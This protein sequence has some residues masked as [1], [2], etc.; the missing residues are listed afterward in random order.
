MNEDFLHFTWKSKRFNQFNLATTDGDLVEII[1]AGLHNHHAGPDF[2][3][4]RVRIGGTLWI[5]NVEIHIKASDWNN[6]KHQFDEAYDNVILHVV[7]EADREIQN[8]KGQTLPAMTLQERM[9]DD[10]FVAYQG[11]LKSTQWVACA[12]QLK[13]VD[14]FIK[15]AWLHRML[16]SRLEQKSERVAL[17]LDQNKNDWEGA[18]YRQ[19]AR[20]FGFKVNAEPFEMLVFHLPLKV[21]AKQLHSSMQIEAMVFGQAGFLE[22][23]FSDA[24]P[25][26]LQK[27][28]QYLKKKHKLNAMAKSIWK[29][30][31]LRPNNFPTIRLA[32]FAAM[33]AH[34]Q[35]LFSRS[36]EAEN[37][38][39]LFT[40]F[41]VQPHS[42]WDDHF[43][44]DKRA[45]TSRPKLLGRAAFENLVINT[46]VPFLFHYGKL[47]DKQHLCDRA[48]QLLE[49]LKPE[50][51]SVV[52]KWKSI[53]M[54][55]LNAFHSQALLELKGAYC[56]QKKCL[57]C[58]IGVTLLKS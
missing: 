41:T 45:T 40:L 17:Y 37:T 55:V 39:E 33:L 53:G 3:T 12:S 8:S 43:Q 11:F 30:G 54:P 6:H 15:E 58:S 51:N 47:K 56:S 42:Y 1:D 9:A 57:N 2:L 18:F 21:I 23:E 38:A 16:V 27:E 5:G 22:G 48:I 7:Y 34:S 4:A 32:Q 46:I 25:N 24:Y 19:L 36:I 44:F 26:A 49:E 35:S 52:K 31:R 20:N 14:G 10:S 28:Y 50:Q 29:F 13:N